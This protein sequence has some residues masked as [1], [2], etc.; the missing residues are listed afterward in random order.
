VEVALQHSVWSAGAVVVVHEEQKRVS[1]LHFPHLVVLLWTSNVAWVAMVVARAAERL[2]NAPPAAA[3]V[4]VQR[5]HETN[6]SCNVR[7]SRTWDAAVV[8]HMEAEAGKG[9]GQVFEVA[10]DQH[11]YVCLVQ[12]VSGVLFQIPS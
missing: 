6:H 9:S 5:F 3:A 12:W 7:V 11:C 10:S 8:P 4:G 2:D 1:L